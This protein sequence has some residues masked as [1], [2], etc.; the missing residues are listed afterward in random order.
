MGLPESSV[1]LRREE[2]DI[3]NVLDRRNDI[4]FITQPFKR[5]I[6]ERF[7]ALFESR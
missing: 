4:P 1:A 6:V 2:W 7:V 3:M 5:Q